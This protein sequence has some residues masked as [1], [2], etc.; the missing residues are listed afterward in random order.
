MPWTRL[1]GLRQ[2]HKG[3]DY[4]TLINSHGRVSLEYVNQPWNPITVCFS[5]DTRA[6]VWTISKDTNEVTSCG[7]STCLVCG[8]KHSKTHTIKGELS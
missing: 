1:P 7:R 3:R 5:G 8:P 6:H 4:F 2:D